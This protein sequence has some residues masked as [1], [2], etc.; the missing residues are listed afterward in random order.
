[1]KKFIELRLDKRDQGKPEEMII[2]L[3]SDSGYDGFIE[4]EGYIL[5]YREAKQLHIEA[6]KAAMKELGIHLSSA[7]LVRDRN[8]NEEWESS[9]QPV[10]IGRDV[11]VRAPFHKKPQ[12]FKWDILID[13]RMAF[14]TAHH[15]TTF[16]MLK[17]IIPMDLEGKKILDMG[18]GTGVLAI[19]AAMKGAARVLAID[20]D[21][22]ASQNARDNVS[23]NGLRNID[24]LQGDAAAIGNEVFDII[25]ANINRNIILED[26]QKYAHALPVGGKM[27]L[28]G[29]Y[30]H[31]I[32]AIRSRAA[33][34]GL[35]ME[36]N[37][38]VN[39]WS[40]CSFTRK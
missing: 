4:E 36:Y 5:A 12:G 1:M 27:L 8:W 38:S 32:R 11:M 39:K 17:H 37:T 25:F 9:Y 26:I 16:M 34:H 24:V 21:E 22:W 29:F 14:G 3:L 19:L 2:A 13:P 15:E 20:N 28:S 18:C 10:T 23:L 7:R 35:S 6:E 31:D 33:E 30:E 40:L